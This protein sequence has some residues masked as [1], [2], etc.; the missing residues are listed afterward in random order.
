[1]T[2]AGHSSHR[3]AFDSLRALSFLG[4]FLYHLNP[5]LFPQ[6]YL[7]VV[8]FF[9]LAGYLSLRK[10]IWQQARGLERPRLGPSL[11]QKIA[12]LY[13]PLIILLFVLSLVMILVFPMFLDHYAGQLRS[14]ILGFNNWWQISLGDSYFQGQAYLKPLTHIWA[15]SLEFQFYLLF[16]LTVERFY[17]S[18]ERSLWLYQFALFSL[19]SLAFL[20]IFTHGVDDPT[21]AYYGTDTRF[22]SFSL[23]SFFALLREPGLARAALEHPGHRPGIRPDPQAS[24]RPAQ[25]RVRGAEAPALAPEAS[26]Y[27]RAVAIFHNILITLLF[28]LAVAA[29]FLPFSLM[30]MMRYGL[31]AYSLI[32]AGLMALLADGENFLEAVGRFPLVAWICSRSYEIYLWHYPVF[33][34]LERLLTPYP[35]PAWALAACQAGLALGLAE[36]AYRL[37]T[38]LRG[39]GFS[40]KKF[41]LSYSSAISLLLALVLLVTPW[42]QVYVVTGGAEFRKLEADLADAEARLEARKSEAA[43][44]KAAGLENVEGREPGG[45]DLSSSSP[46]TTTTHP[47]S[48]ETSAKATRATGPGKWKIK[49]E[50]HIPAPQPI[51]D[52]DWQYDMMRQDMLDF[53]ELEG[54]FSVDMDL[55]DQYRD[56][57]ISMI[58]DSVS[59]INSYYIFPY[60]PGLDLDALSNRQMW[61]VWDIYSQ[62]KAAGPLGEIMI[63]AL[64]SNGDIDTET[65]TKVWRDLDGKPLILVNIV[66]P[67]ALTEAERNGALEDFV[68]SHDQVYLVDWHANAK[69]RPDYFQEDYIHPSELGSK[70]YCQLLT[71]KV[72]EIVKLYKDSDL[73]TVTPQTPEVNLP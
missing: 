68:D 9:C 51:A 25:P 73:V 57:P 23:G 5:L 4:V 39:S 34:I 62:L 56:I 36:L 53:N 67:Y 14:A 49:G 60:L 21:R 48:P 6:A 1:M 12:K 2:R 44:R 26:S 20:W 38:F 29:Y 65:L 13:P 69:T 54:D 11:R 45:S 35:I 64:G 52:D 7:G 37:V 42:Q 32:Y 10:L 46:E 61:E 50:L 47:T 19:G 28:L 16:S 59:V 43:S 24:T 41:A 30:D 55:Y 8:G 18:S 33:V 71:A 40:L 22:F 3:Y 63:I 66:L 27:D 72:M 70:A 58:G 31:P 17:R 15:L